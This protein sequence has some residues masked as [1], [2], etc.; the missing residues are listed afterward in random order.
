MLSFI[1]SVMRI[2]QEIERD[3]DTV[4]VV[5]AS[6]PESQSRLNKIAPIFHNLGYLVTHFEATNTFEISWKDPRSISIEI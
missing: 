1:E 6:S 3:H 5:R 2:I 4:F